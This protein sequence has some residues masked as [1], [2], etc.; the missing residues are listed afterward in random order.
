VGEFIK[1]VAPGGQ[2]WHGRANL[3]GGLS[4]RVRAGSFLL[5]NLD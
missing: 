5:T 4:V 2:Y 1:D 3:A